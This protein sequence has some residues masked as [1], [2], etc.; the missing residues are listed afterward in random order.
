M[1]LRSWMW[2]FDDRCQ[3]Q[4]YG[5]YVLA[6]PNSTLDPLCPR[7]VGYYALE[8]GGEYKPPTQESAD[9]SVLLLSVN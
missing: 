7:L 4:I 3:C 5:F 8:N 2:L 1:A 6:L 9:M